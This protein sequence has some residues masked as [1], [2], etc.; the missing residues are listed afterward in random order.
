MSNA[1]RD[2][3]GLLQSCSPAGVLS[4]TFH[5]PGRRNALNGPMYQ[6]AARALRAARLD[7][8]V[9]VILLSGADGYFTAGNDLSDFIG[10]DRR[11]EFLPAAFLRELAACDKP[12]VAAVEG[13]AIGVGATMLL[14]CDFVF[15][16]R[17]TRFHL[18]FIHLNVCPEGGS[19]VLLPQRA[20]AHRAARW[21][22]LGE[23]FT[24][25]QAQEGD[26]V[27]E[28][29]N[30]G[31]ALQVAQAVADRLAAFDPVSMRTSKRLLRGDL[32]ALQATMAVELAHFTE[33]LVQPAAQQALQRMTQG[34]TRKDA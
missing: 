2:E 3:E 29:V 1:W 9:R 30:D 24:A 5:R 17:S 7:E 27:T 15:A 16:A 31:G 22:L 20:G 34:K 13:G 26:L 14:H 6:A 8:G 12:V 11:D 28:V 32:P 23:P 18:P 10:Y 33:L 19:S 4:L 21:L 25:A